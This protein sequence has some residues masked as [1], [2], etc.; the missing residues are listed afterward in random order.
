MSTSSSQAAAYFLEH[1]TQFHLGVLPTEQSNPKTKGLEQTFMADT[2]AGV[3]MLLTVDRDITVMA[4]KVMASDEYAKLVE[5]A[6]NTAAN[7]G[8]IIFSG[9]GATGRLSILLESMWRGFFTRLKADKPELYRKAAVYE[10]CVYSI[11]TGGDF[12]LIR[13]VESFEDYP[14]FG[15]RQAEELE[16]SAAD[17]LVAITEGGETSSVLGSLDEAL[18]RGAAGF[19]LF[20]NPADILCRYIERSRQAIKDSRVTV[21]DL[22]C[23]PMALAGSTR[24][25]ATTSEQL[26]AGSMLEKILLRLLRGVLSETELEEIDGGDLDYVSEFDRALDRLTATENTAQIAAFVDYEASIYREN[27]LVT[28]FANDFLLDIFT[29]TTERNPTFMLPPFA[30]ADDPNAAPSWAF[31]KHPQ[32]STEELWQQVLGRAPRC[33]D[34]APALY[35]RL[36]APAK[37]IDDPPRIDLFNLLR[38][39]VGNEFDPARISRRPNVA[40]KVLGSNEIDRDGLADWEQAFELATA[41]FQKKKTFIIGAG[42]KDYNADFRVD[43]SPAA[44]PLNLIRRLAIKI[45]LNTLSTGAMVK[46]GRVTGNWMSW[47]AVSNKKLIDRGIRLISELCELSYRDACYAL[48]ESIEELAAKDFTG[49]EQPSP[50]Q[51]TIRKYRGKIQ[52]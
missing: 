3:K 25:Q 36:N 13:S 38:I 35:R 23:G 18:K 11:M 33:L 2:A 39:K 8:R 6:Y 51:Y 32:Y 21:L 41:K 16:V 17:M 47:V 42:D 52:T 28:Y 14:Q 31:V 40:I 48:H 15:R 19:L 44:S 1:E 20:N 7:H 4:R 34:W 9:C 43:C 24:M 26:I 46:V 5:T 22:Y 10:D 45:T 29:D 30:P 49:A 12:A 27:G 37:V 50:V